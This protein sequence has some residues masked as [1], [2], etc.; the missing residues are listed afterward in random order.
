MRRAVAS[1]AAASTA[2]A[3]AAAVAAA[4]T[5]VVSVSDTTRAAASAADAALDHVESTA[6]ARSGLG[7][8]EQGAMVCLQRNDPLDLWGLVGAWADEPCPL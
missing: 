1:L 4:A 7:L 8:I 6:A 2:A 5:I 3:T